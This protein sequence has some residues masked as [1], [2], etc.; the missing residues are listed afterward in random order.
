MS[1][2]AACECVSTCMELELCAAEGPS[3]WSC[4]EWA[5]SCGGTPTTK[6]G[7][8]VC[9]L[10]TPLVPVCRS[11]LMVSLS[12]VYV[13]FDVATHGRAGWPSVNAKL[14]R[15]S[16]RHDMR[17]LPVKHPSCC[18]VRVRAVCL[19]IERCL[20][21]VWAIRTAIIGSQGLQHYLVL[22]HSQIGWL[23]LCQRCT[24]I[25]GQYSMQPALL[26]STP[27]YYIHT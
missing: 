25:P 13:P 3:G 26:C 2:P 24:C 18:A 27:P 9:I 8:F 22:M 17:V 16:H 15:S 20:D 6:M 10:I 21:L 23:Y 19:A 11:K 12:Y 7:T 14:S 4:T 1:P 5:V